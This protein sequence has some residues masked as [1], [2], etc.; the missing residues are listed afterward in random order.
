MRCTVVHVKI[1]DPL[2]VSD[3]GI[4]EIMGVPS[5]HVV[6]YKPEIPYNTGNI[7]RLCANI[8]A[9]LHLIRPLGFEMTESRL[10]RAALDYS[11]LTIVTERESLDSYLLDFPERRLF[12]ASA[13]A[14]H[15][16]AE[17]EYREN[18]SFLFGSESSG[19]P[20]DLLSTFLEER[21]LLVPMMPNNRCLNIANSVSI[22]AYEAWRQLGFFG[23]A[24]PR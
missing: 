8:G 23:R 5:F 7:I 2:S 22:I 17:T 20:D 16:Y 3:K 1:F 18:D 14:K 24:D 21:K 13:K 12:A 9:E 11:D 15:S 19:L 10:R 6:L 4:I